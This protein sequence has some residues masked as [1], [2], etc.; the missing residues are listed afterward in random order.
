MAKRDPGKYPPPPRYSVAV[1]SQPPLTSNGQG[2]GSYPEVNGIYPSLKLSSQPSYIPQYPPPVVAPQVTEIGP[3]PKEKKNC[4][5]EKAQIYKVTAAVI[6]LL[7]LLGV[8]IWLGVYYGTSTLRR[9]VFIIP[10]NEYNGPYGVYQRVN[11]TC[12][13]NFTQCDGI[14]DCQ[15]GTD[16]TYCVRF[17]EGNSLLV[18]TAQRDFLP[19]CYSG[20]DTNYANQICSQLGFRQSFSSNKMN[21]QGSP[22]LKL[23]SGSPSSL[24]QA[25]VG[26]NSSCP[27]QESVSLQCVDCGRRPAMSRIIG[28]TAAKS[29]E[30]P[31]QVSL[32]FLRHHTCGGSLISPDFVVT[33]AH[34]FPSPE[35]RLAQN[36]KVYGGFMSLNDLPSPFL[37]EKI[38]INENY[39]SKTNDQDVA[40]LKLKYPV[41]FTDKL[42]PACL[43]LYG[44]EFRDGTSCWTSGYGTTVS[45]SST[46]STDLMEVSVDI[47]STTACNSPSAYSGAV[48]NTMICAG[49]MEGGKDS[50]QGDSGGPLVCQN[51]GDSPWYLIGITSW[52]AGCGEQNKPGVYTKVSA[53]LP[54]IYSTMQQERP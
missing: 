42:Q 25:S 16:E 12:P 35:Y 39:N 3:P 51:Q 15:L 6:V 36:W 47:I 52:G 10:D 38:L 21:S 20:W 8:G 5:E 53:V 28:G 19:V 17:G 48:T 24:I 23:N 54:W 41:T 4:C 44:Q 26:V 32:Q 50:C 45:G 29:G 2:Y 11:D 43:P 37:V 31:W 34:C 22:G 18:K 40:L 9:E 7:A 14:K 46:V 1:H 13:S 49:K 30:W 27:N 33:A